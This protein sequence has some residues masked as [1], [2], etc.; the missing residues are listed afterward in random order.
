MAT[1]KQ[2]KKR[3]RGSQAD[4]GG[5]GSQS[6][7]NGAAELRCPTEWSRAVLERLREAKD[8]QMM[9]EAILRTELEPLP[10]DSAVEVR[11]VPGGAASPGAYGPGAS[12]PNE[13]PLHDASKPVASQSPQV[14][15][16][17][18]EQRR[19]ERS[20]Y[21]Q[22]LRR[23]ARH[24]MPPQ[25][26]K[27]SE[28][29]IAAR[30][31]SAVQA[32]ERVPSELLIELFFQ[33]LRDRA[34]LIDEPSGCVRAAHVLMHHL[35]GLPTSFGPDMVTNLAAV[36]SG[37]QVRTKDADFSISI[38]EVSKL[39]DGAR[40]LLQQGE[41]EYGVAALLA[42]ELSLVL[43]ECCA[44]PSALLQALR[45]STKIARTTDILVACDLP[46][47]RPPRR[48]YR[49]SRRQIDNAVRQALP[50]EEEGSP[51]GA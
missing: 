33:V 35:A 6:E 21:E 31:T 45:G 22:A 37:A 32:M 20:Q 47:Y 36:A 42:R 19:A 49:F 18:W 13:A 4:G 40:L 25:V 41:P 5:G 12:I 11:W 29:E 14:T 8:P 17:P 16:R 48:P 9:L 28:S 46:Q 10:P 43:G 1:K 50:P 34:E 7:A 23:L 26:D 51:S 3:S 2:G 30:A 24:P 44:A 15:K 38:R 39:A 27:L